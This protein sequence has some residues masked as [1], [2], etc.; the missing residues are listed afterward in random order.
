MTFDVVSVISTKCL[1][2]VK[3]MIVVKRDGVVDRQGCS[4]I[5]GSSSMPSQGPSPPSLPSIGSRRHEHLSV[6]EQEGTAQMVLKVAFW[7]ISVSKLFQ[8]TKSIL[9]T[10]YLEDILTS[11]CVVEVNERVEGIMLSCNTFAKV[12]QVVEMF[13]MERV[14][15]G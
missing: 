4:Y 7:V 1:G 12:K 9:R 3:S 6:P 15:G 5:D 10:Q 13:D 8:L 11:C 2:G 14:E